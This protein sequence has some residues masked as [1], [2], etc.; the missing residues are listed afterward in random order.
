MILQD[1]SPEEIRRMARDVALES[2]SVQMNSFKLVLR[3]HKCI[4]KMFER[5]FIF[6]FYRSTGKSL[7][8]NPNLCA[9]I[10]HP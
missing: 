5:C 8:Q 4:N 6:L 10:I 9:Y 3:V 7:R 2:I 1:K